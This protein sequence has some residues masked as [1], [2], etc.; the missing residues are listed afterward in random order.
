[1]HLQ[2]TLRKRWPAG[3]LAL[4]VLAILP[5][6]MASAGASVTKPTPATTASARLT[7]RSYPPTPAGPRGPIRISC[8]PGQTGVVGSD[9]P[10]GPQGPIGVSCSPAP[11][12]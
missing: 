9:G 11:Q 3:L 6:A 10:A 1:M 12:G 7:A 8:L 5:F 4:I 2:K